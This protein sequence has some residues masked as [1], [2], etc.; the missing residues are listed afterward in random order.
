MQKGRSYRTEVGCP[1]LHKQLLYDKTK[2]SFFD[3]GKLRGRGGIAYSPVM[4]LLILILT[5]LVSSYICSF[6]LRYKLYLFFSAI[7]HS[8]ASQSKSHPP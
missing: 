7:D 8:V 1:R 6:P 2:L 5:S 3:F 4:K